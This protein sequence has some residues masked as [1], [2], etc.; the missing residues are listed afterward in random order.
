M[1]FIVF[2]FAV[3]WSVNDYFYVGGQMNVE[4]LAGNQASKR[5]SS[6][7]NNMNRLFASSK[8]AHYKSLTHVI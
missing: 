7:L 1:A 4:N 2:L 8:S 3:T 6:C 5:E